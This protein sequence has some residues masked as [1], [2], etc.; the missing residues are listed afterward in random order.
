VAKIVVV[1][2]DAELAAAIAARLRSDGHCVTVAQD[3]PSAVQVV[4]AARPDAVFS[5]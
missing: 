3:G 5:I 1:D 4:A 2:D